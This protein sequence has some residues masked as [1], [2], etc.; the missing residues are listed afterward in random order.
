[1][2][3]PIGDGLMNFIRMLNG[4]LRRNVTRVVLGQLIGFLLWIRI[5]IFL[6]GYHR[7]PSIP[8]AMIVRILK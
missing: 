7:G 1:M 4:N 2:V 3:I 8:T 6:V 5:E